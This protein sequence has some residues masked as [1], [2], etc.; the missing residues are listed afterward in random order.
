[1]RLA[2]E[3]GVQLIEAGRFRILIPESVTC[4]IWLAAFRRSVI[5][6]RPGSASILTKP[7]EAWFSESVAVNA[8]SYPS[9]GADR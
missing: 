8:T 5:T 6:G 3:P 4:E 2:T 7:V 1:M 9:N